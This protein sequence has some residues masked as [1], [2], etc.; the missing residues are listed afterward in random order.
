MRGLWLRFGAWRSS[1]VSK[2]EFFIL[3]NL[4][5]KV[6]LIFLE[7]VDLGMVRMSEMNIR[8]FNISKFLF[9]I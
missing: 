8:K 2:M 6:F 9:I 3:S 7:D 5:S 4:D 1:R